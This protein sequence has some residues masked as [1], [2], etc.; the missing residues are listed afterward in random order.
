MV[1]NLY[2][3]KIG[4]DCKSW[5]TFHEFLGWRY[6]NYN[7]LKKNKRRPIVYKLVDGEYKRIKF[8]V[9]VDLLDD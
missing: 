3:A 5:N 6:N 4:N 9:E 2:V 1:Q 7:E 8:H